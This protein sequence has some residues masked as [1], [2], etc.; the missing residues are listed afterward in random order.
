MKEL[1]KD[2]FRPLDNDYH[3]L[4]GKVKLAMRIFVAIVI[5]IP[6]LPIFYLAFWAMGLAVV[7]VITA[8]F[9]MLF[10]WL[11]NNEETIALGLQLAQIAIFL[12]V[13]PFIFWAFFIRGDNP[14]EELG[15]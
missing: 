13:A 9:V 5:G 11:T 7:I 10:G 8:P 15:M 3:T 12:F 4:S 2:L 14:L 6:T 1:Y